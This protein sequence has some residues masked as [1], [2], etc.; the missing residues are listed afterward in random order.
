LLSL[1]MPVFPDD[2]QLPVDV[3][4]EELDLLSQK[5]RGS[6]LEWLDAVF[7][8]WKGQEGEQPVIGVLATSDLL[9][10]GPLPPDA[11]AWRCAG[12]F[13]WNRIDLFLRLWGEEY[14]PLDDA[15]KSNP[16]LLAKALA[17]LIVSNAE[18][19]NYRSVR[20]AGDILIRLHK[21]RDKWVIEELAKR[22]KLGIDTMQN[23]EKGR[24]A[25]RVAK[26]ERTAQLHVRWRQISADLWRKNPRLTLD[27]QVDYIKKHAP[28]RRPSGKPYA[29]RTIKEVIKGVRS[30]GA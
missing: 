13:V 27:D 14:V 28:G 10:T 25:A 22:A 12:P 3:A 2:L 17:I 4:E 21:A 30:Y 16:D 1:G 20:R 5:Q 6:L 15:L 8:Y 24:S 9:G 18:A 19:A 23:L 29:S 7:L 26:K 11:P